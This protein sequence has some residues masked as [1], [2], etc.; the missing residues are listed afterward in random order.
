MALHELQRDF[1][2]RVLANDNALDAQL[3]DGE[4]DDFEA[5]L[6]AYVGGYRARL[7]DALGTTY[8]VV[9]ATLGDEEFERQMRRY[10]DST[11]S[12][13]FSVR[14]Y[15]A[16]IADHLLTREPESN[17]QV[18]AELAAWEWTLA[19][20][21]DAPDDD[22][23]AVATLATVPPQA[24]PT[25]SFQLRQSLRRL[26]TRTNAVEWWRAANGLA[27]QPSAMTL[28]APTEWL[29]WRRGVTTLFRSLEPLEAELLDA[30]QRGATFGALCERVAQD[31]DESEAAL[32]AAS[33]LRAW[34]ADELV[35]GYA[36][37]SS[38]E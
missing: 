11:P 15:G 12:R 3:R 28:A 1:Q 2:A 7:V 19:D 8:P 10:I 4:R 36:L 34:I 27:E 22:P 16:T 5:R 33:L 32:R 35:A 20:V 25:V 38:P 13:H 29:L 18:L 31:I 23:L 26:E 17:G 30:A 9:K 21:F 14:H 37:P 6:D 24:W